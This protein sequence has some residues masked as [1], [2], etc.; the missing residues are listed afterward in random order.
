METPCKFCGQVYLSDKKTEIERFKDAI[1]QCNC[2]GAY[3]QKRKWD[4]IANAEMELI[5]VFEFNPFNGAVGA[6]DAEVA[7]DIR[8]KMEQFIPYLVDYDISSLVVKI[9]GIGKVTMNS[10][11]DGDIKISRQ[12]TTG[13]ERKVKS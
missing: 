5:S 11:S 6:A 9:A 3:V 10:N 8:E 12:V 1:E 4:K 13:I 2:A 7:A